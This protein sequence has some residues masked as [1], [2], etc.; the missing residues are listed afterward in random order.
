MRKADYFL[1]GGLFVQNEKYIMRAL[2]EGDKMDYLK[3]YQENAIVTKAALTLAE[4]DYDEYIEYVWKNLSEDDTINVSVFQKENF[5]YVGNI[6]LRNLSSDTPEIGI[7]VLKKY[8]RQGIAFETIP[9]FAKRVLELRRVEY[10][11]VRIYSDNEASTKLFEKLGVTRIGKE[12]SE[13]A[14]FLF[15]LKEKYGD[16]Y[17]EIL[18]SSTESEKIANRNHIIHYKYIPS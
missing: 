13:Y 2:C 10:F 11:L 3:L 18:E 1:E 5:V 6:V 4:I 14:A 7:D 9:M 17:K 12:P 15:Q 8:H 16:L